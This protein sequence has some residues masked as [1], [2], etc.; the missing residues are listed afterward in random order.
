MIN[1]V[2]LVT[3]LFF[4]SQWRKT[5]SDKTN[6]APNCP[7][8]SDSYKM[9]TEQTAQ[10]CESEAGGEESSCMCLTMAQ[11][12]QPGNVSSVL[13]GITTHSLCLSPPTLTYSTSAVASAGYPL[14]A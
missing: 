7:F 11:A 2:F 3:L 4:Y 9:S 8:L 10:V 12:A 5:T 6:C 1:S 13:W 14:T